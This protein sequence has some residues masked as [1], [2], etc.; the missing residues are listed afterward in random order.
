MG[1]KH[2]VTINGR[3]YDA[4]T[5]KLVDNHR[6][7]QQ[8]AEVPQPQKVAVTPAVRR[9]QP[10]HAPAITKHSKTLRRDIVQRPVGAHEKTAVRPKPQHAH[11]S[12]SPAITRF[13]PHPSSPPHPVVDETVAPSP[14]V[15]A[16][17]E[18]AKKHKKSTPTP[19]QTPKQL[20]ESLI[21]KQ[22]AAAP[23]K[24]RKAHAQPK[25]PFLARTLRPSSVMASCMALIL[26]G[27]Y[28]TYLN[29]PSLSMRVA[30]SQAGINASYP[31]Y[32]PS[33]YRFE[34]PVAYQSGEVTMSFAANGGNT[35][36]NITQKKTTWDSQA[37]LDN[38]VAL[39]TK[40]YS[41]TNSQGL[42]IYT[43][44]TD[45][46]WINGGILHTIEGN[47]PLSTEQVLR[48]AQS[49]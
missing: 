7:S 43:Y 2:T 33:G 9:T 11:I 5:G 17:H 25:A 21:K 3:V 38:Y 46:A 41:I 22:L 45:A 27:G 15:A 32:Q 42:T 37:V 23:V 39:K 40:D 13:A 36:Y 14:I 6:T 28:L 10:Q 30:A 1:N 47:A 19:H 18:R 12:R 31:G 26:L 48:I 20:K 16:I 4:L 49:M 24:S 35:K 8:H 34:G 29:M 44:N